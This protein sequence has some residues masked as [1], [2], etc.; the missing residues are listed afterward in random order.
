MCAYTGG[1][2]HLKARECGGG[3]YFMVHDLKTGIWRVSE[4]EAVQV[5][6]MVLSTVMMSSE[7]IGIS[8]CE[9][10][11]EVCPINEERE[12]QCY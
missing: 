11:G 5:H 3:N 12:H 7:V 9:L 2:H 4:D 1:S 10:K 8:G 6:R